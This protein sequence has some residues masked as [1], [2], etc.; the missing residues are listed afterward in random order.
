MLEPITFGKH[1]VPGIWRSLLPEDLWWLDPPDERRA[2]CHSCYKVALGDYRDDCRC[3]TYFPR[4]PNFMLGL[5]L[6]QPASRPHVERVIESGSAL[7]VGLVPS[8][9]QYCAAVEAQAND[10][11][12]NLP[13]M[14]CPFVEPN[15]FNCGIYSNRNSVCS[16]FFCVNDHGQ[17]G[18]KFWQKLQQL[19]GHV[20]STVALWAMNHVGLDYT[21]YIS[22]LDQQAS[23]LDQLVDKSGAWSVSVRRELW[24]EWFGRESEFFRCCADRALA[25]KQGLYHIATK[26]QLVEPL[27]YESAVR[28]AIPEK[29]REAT[30]EMNR[31]DQYQPIES[32]W[33]QVQL[34]ARNLWQLPF[35]E[36]I[37]LDENVELQQPADGQAVVVYGEHSLSVGPERLAVLRLLGTPQTLDTRFFELDQVAALG[38]SRRALAEWMRQGIVVCAA[39]S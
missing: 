18:E 7:P 26:Q 6:C 27:A 11:F 15:T 9:V 33:Y 3:C 8:S 20:E 5:A 23:Q 24:G 37:T 16:T 22:R 2:T 13:E 34:A 21:D 4:I 29:H 30:P 1:T 36:A 31:S 28:F 17:S 38:Q 12:G 39:N 10:L 25:E 32:M 35:G 19:V 14:L